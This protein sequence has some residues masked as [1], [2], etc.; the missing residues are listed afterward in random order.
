MELQSGATQGEFS[1]KVLGTI[2]TIGIIVAGLGTLSFSSPAQ[3]RINP[4][5]CYDVY[6]ACD[7]GDQAAC[8]SRVYQ[9][10]LREG[11]PP[12]GFAPALPKAPF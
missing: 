9:T 12:A 7:A 2:G 8:D 3:A 1:M 11:I 10:C 5:T 6:A 4:Q